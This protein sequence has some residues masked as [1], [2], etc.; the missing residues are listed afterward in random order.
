MQ[1]PTIEAILGDS[2]DYV[3]YDSARGKTNFDELVYQEQ[4]PTSD[5]KQVLAMFY[6]SKKAS[7]YEKRV[8]IITKHLAAKYDGSLYFERFGCLLNRVCILL[9]VIVAVQIGVLTVYYSLNRGFS[10]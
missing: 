9:V 6:D 1:L 5:R 7:E 10:G 4:L 3:R 2:V 8:A